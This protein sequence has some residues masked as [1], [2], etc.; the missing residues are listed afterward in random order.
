MNTTTIPT[1]RPTQLRERTTSSLMADVLTPRGATAP[2]GFRTAEGVVRVEPH[3]PVI[4]TGRIGRVYRPG[5]EKLHAW[6]TRGPTGGGTRGK[7]T[8]R[9]AGRGGRRGATGVEPV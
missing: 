4:L 8:P 1:A 3:A 6:M 2:A 7:E 9:P 5:L